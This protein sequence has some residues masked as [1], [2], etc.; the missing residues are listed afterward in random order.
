MLQY[1]TLFSLI[2]DHIN[3]SNSI[4]Q[5]RKGVPSSLQHPGSFWLSSLQ[6]VKLSV[7]RALADRELRIK[8]YLVRITTEDTHDLWT[9]A[10]PNISPLQGHICWINTLSIVL[11]RLPSLYSVFSFEE[12][13]LQ[14]NPLPGTSN[15]RLLCRFGLC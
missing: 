7:V 11:L 13:I 2:Q 14:T 5:A 8:Q 12:Q 4:P 9:R 6:P 15:A 3:C 1:S 10:S